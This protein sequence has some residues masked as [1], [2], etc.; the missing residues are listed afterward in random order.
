M[1][2][3]DFSSSV[4]YHQPG[5][6]GTPF[7][8]FRPNVEIGDMVEVPAAI[9]IVLGRAAP[10]SAETVPL[11]AALG[12]VIAEAVA[13]D[14]DSPPFTKALMD[15]YAVRS[16]DV[17]GPATLTV[18]EEVGAGQ[19]PIRPLGRAQATRIMTGAPIPDGADA[20]IPHEETKA[21]G[22]TV[23]VSRTVRAGESI[24]P[25]GREMR[26]GE[27]VVSP[28]TWLTPQSIGLLAAVGRVKVAV[29]RA[30][31][32]AVLATGDEL[33]EPDQRPTAG[34]I[35]NSNGA[36]LAALASR[37]GAEVHYLG[38]ARDERVA[39]TRLVARGLE[40]AEMLVLAGGVSAGKFDLVPGV[41]AE[42][43]VTG[44]FH[45]VRMKPGKPLLFGTKDTK[46]VFGLPGNPVSSFVGF[47]LFVRPALRKMMGHAEPGPMFVPI[48]LAAPLRAK[49]DR[50]TFA[51][52]KLEWTGGLRLRP[53]DWFGSADLRGL[54]AADALMSLP[55]GAVELAA[56]DPLPALLL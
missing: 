44:H 38:I 4:S 19:T 5:C 10:L 12:R 53:T 8:D 42:F 13:S 48:Q 47:E 6:F 17:A 11:A 15:G 27:S 25:R 40:S 3:E 1:I 55:A 46:L 51:P 31:R 43:G 32:V 21:D 20:V 28:G 35:R 52:A 2:G 9:E 50:P 45:K 26:E 39:L 49:S 24:L 7:A 22:D 37:V 56:G 54:L 16:V 23:Q 14:I 34:Q 33:V 29:H 30:P 41:L 18:I 36:M